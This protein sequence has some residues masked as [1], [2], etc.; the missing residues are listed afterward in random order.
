MSIF[1]YPVAR[2]DLNYQYSHAASTSSQQVL[3]IVCVTSK[4]QR[5]Q[6]FF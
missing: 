4:R 5:T 3:L 1:L 2:G 6:I